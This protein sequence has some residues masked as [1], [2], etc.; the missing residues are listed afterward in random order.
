MERPEISSVCHGWVAAADGTLLAT[1]QLGEGPPLVVC[2]GA[3]TVAQDWL[4][5]AARLAATRRVI[6]Y[7]RRG[8]GQSVAAK[9]VS[10]LNAELE[11]LAAIVDNAGPDTAILGHSFGGACAL[12]YAAQSGFSGQL[13]VYEPPHPAR[14]PVSRGLIPQIEQLIAAGNLDA[15]AAFAM[16]QVV[17]MP[18]PAID[19]FR[20]TPLWQTMSATVTAFPAELH[21]LDRLTWQSG[22][23]D[24]IAGPT[25]LLLGSETP[26]LPDSLWPVAS[27]QALLPCL[28]IVHVPGQGHVAYLTDP[29]GLA[30]IV[31]ECLMNGQAHG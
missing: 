29:D 31:A 20:A 16:T 17:G 9:P 4:P 27:L 3:F 30:A 22:D 19:A 8:R 28:R 26:D 14:G 1:M 10:A 21:L 18:P 6:L 15:A 23:L 12:A 11:D 25:T 2:H 13:I 24:G 5:F 7:D